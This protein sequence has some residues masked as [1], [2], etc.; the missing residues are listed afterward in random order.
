[1]ILVV[2]DVAVELR[3]ATSA[4]VPL[5]LSFIRSMAEFENL[6]VTATEESLRAALFGEA[7][8]ARVLLAFVRGEP[9]AYATY[10]FTFASMVGK[11]GLWLD[12]LFVAP[13]FRGRG[14]GKAFMAYLADVAIRHQ[15]GRLEWMVLDWNDTAIGFYERLGAS[16][17]SNWRMCRLEESQL[18]GVADQLT[19]VREGKQAVAAGES[20][21]SVPKNDPAERGVL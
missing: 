20:Q 7:P 3:D 8:A 19:V 5:L 15:C 6:P 21:R 13:A 11:R 9:A 1:M 12:D 2:N 17:H 4:D 10:F 18:R 14:I 16:V